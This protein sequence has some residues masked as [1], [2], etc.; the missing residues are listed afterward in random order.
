MRTAPDDPAGLSHLPRDFRP[1]ER[2]SPGACPL[3]IDRERSS[4]VIV[5]AK[6]GAVSGKDQRDLNVIGCIWASDLTDPHSR[7]PLRPA[8]SA[9]LTKTPKPHGFN[10]GT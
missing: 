9:S 1:D 8:P 3:S 5:A 2:R 4:S 7:Y 10:G 6:A